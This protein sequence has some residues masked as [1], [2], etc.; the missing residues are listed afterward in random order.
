MRR[1][2]GCLLSFP[3]IIILF[4]H[5]TIFGSVS[6]LA[7]NDSALTY[8]ELA[9][10]VMPQYAEPDEWE[11]GKPALLIGMHGILKNTS[12][13]P[14][15][16]E[17]RFPVP[18]DELDFQ[19]SLTGEFDDEGA[20]HDTD[21]VLDEE[22][23]EVVWQLE[24][25]L[26][27]GDSYRFVMEYFYNPFEEGQ[28]HRFEYAYELDM[29]AELLN[30]LFFEPVGAEDFTVSGGEPDRITEMLSVSVH[31]FEMEEAEAGASFNKAVSY[32]KQDG[33]TTVEAMETQMTPPDD[34]IHA[35]FYNN[36]AQGS[37]GPLIETEGALMIS[38]AIV[39]AGLFIFFG[40]R[41]GRREPAF[42][43]KK[44]Q[45]P[46]SPADADAEVKM[47][48]QK[49]IRGEIDEETYRKE[50]SKHLS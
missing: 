43:R 35:Q 10:Q 5:G 11:P 7:D 17:I 19:L 4:F 23:G 25:S 3:V 28:P 41:S 44:N 33:V 46:A 37:G 32:D 50:R 14:F 31:V 13:S 1:L 8:E 49:L 45:Q 39:I 48:R 36:G 40:L 16:E 22:S 42:N 47:L 2:G 15:S 21:A 29:D 38:L 26:E 34:D 30:L 24:D 20:V 6:V 12:G 27:P 9:I 18:Y